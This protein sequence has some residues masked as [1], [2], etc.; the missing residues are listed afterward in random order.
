MYGI[1]VLRMYRIPP[2]LPPPKGCL[3]RKALDADSIAKRYDAGYYRRKLPEKFS[4][5]SAPVASTNSPNPSTKHSSHR[6]ALQILTPRLG[7]TLPLFNIPK[8]M[9][10]QMSFLLMRPALGPRF[11]PP[12]GGHF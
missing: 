4:T 8:A 2:I 6:T 9:L 11:W 12:S 1:F 10:H 3:A 5:V 7:C